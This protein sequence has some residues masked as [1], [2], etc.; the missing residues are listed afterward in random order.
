MKLKDPMSKNKKVIQN[1]KNKVKYTESKKPK[2][3]PKI[4]TRRHFTK[5]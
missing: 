5:K 3:R 4:K 2:K 1:N